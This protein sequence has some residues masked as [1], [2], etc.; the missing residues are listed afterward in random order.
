MGKKMRGA[1]MLPLL[2]LCALS[3][4]IP[5]SA[6]ELIRA[7]YLLAEPLAH[8]AVVQALPAK[9]QVE[10]LERRGG[11]SRVRAGALEGWLRLLALRDNRHNS[12]SG[13]SLGALFNSDKD[14]HSRITGVAG[15]RGLPSP[16]PSAHAL[17]LTIGEYRNGIPRLKGV[18]HDAESAALMASALGVPDENI[19]SLN[20]AA[21]T[22][23]G[24]R[25]ALDGLEARVMPNDEVFL[26]YSGHGTRLPAFDGREKRCA[27]A[28]LTIDGS[29]LLDSE[30]EQRLQRIAAKARRVVVFV[31]ACHAGGVTLRDASADG[32][33]AKFF[34]KSDGETCERPINA[35]TRSLIVT[36]ADADAGNGKLNFVHIAAARDNEAALD[37]GVRGGLAT[38]AWLDCLAGGATDLDGSTGL[39]A[40]ELQACAQPR[41]EQLA[42]GNSRFSAHHLTLN[43]NVDMVLAGPDEL[44]PNANPTA[45]LKDIHANRDDRRIVLLEADKTAYKIGQ[46]RVRFNLTSSHAGYVYLLMAGSD[47]K[48]FDLLFP[49]KRDDRNRIQAKETLALPR[50][51]WAFK[52]GGPAGANQ[53][54]AIVS[55]KPRNFSGIGMRPSGPFSSIGTTSLAA[56][57][58]QFV[59]AGVVQTTLPECA[60]TGALRTTDIAAACSDGYGADLISLIEID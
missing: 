26:Y 6:A 10:V 57:D 47:G 45:V 28:L 1:A 43:G 46:D 4:N 20:D 53:L 54:L 41:I 37:D 50:A 8:A 12:W 24:L 48:H 29:A 19:T 44:P 59:S 32:F 38:Q 58:I 16:R 56:R 55:D 40:R 21:L 52:A 27:E 25:A 5:A 11:W 22:L 3:F 13:L 60:M 42:Q 36:E 33:S 35:L 31:D 51:G 39:S 34:A 23:D 2:A 49:N 18:A 15:I 7:Q 17:I 30:L 14:R 9:T